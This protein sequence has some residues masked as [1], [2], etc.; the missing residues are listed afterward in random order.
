M[1]FSLSLCRMPLSVPQSERARDALIKTIYA[2]LYDWLVRRINLRIA[3]AYVDANQSRRYIGILDMP[4][5][6]ETK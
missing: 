2:N 1:L 5:F 6:G 4:G 3:P